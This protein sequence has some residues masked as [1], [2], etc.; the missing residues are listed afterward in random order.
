MPTFNDLYYTD[1]G[2]ADLEPEYAT[3][4]D[5]GMNWRHDSYT[6]F[7]RSFEVN[8]DGYHNRISN[9]IIAVPKGSGQYRWMMMN[10]GKVHIW[11]ADISAQSEFALPADIALNLRLSYTY[12][13]AMDYTD[14][15]DNDKPA[16]SYKGQ[17]SYIPE[18]SGSVVAA[19]Y[20]R[21]FNLNYSFIYTGQRY[22]NSSNIQA[23][24]EH[25]HRRGQQPLQS[26]VRGDTQLPYARPQLSFH[27]SI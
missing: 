8:V 27:P 20:W 1:I 2:N 19:A 7:C 3:Q 13:R 10:I 26:A 15:T 18:H 12:Q 23:N 16:G 17:I 14:P 4:Y 21:N 9:K 6:S 22:H 24:L 11:G 25:R 5:L